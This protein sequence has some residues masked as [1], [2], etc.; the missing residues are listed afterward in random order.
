MPVKNKET[1]PCYLIISYG[2]ITS[3]WFQF[4]NHEI[5]F[6]SIVSYFP[7]EFLVSLRSLSSTLEIFLDALWLL[8]QY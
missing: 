5:L 6:T 7:T 1:K 8:H 4:F 3:K 2:S